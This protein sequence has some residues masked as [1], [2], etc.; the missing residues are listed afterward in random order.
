[1]LRI[2]KIFLAL[3]FLININTLQLN[4]G[5]AYDND[6]PITTDTRIKTYIYNQNEVYLLVMHYGFQ[7]FIEFAKNEI[8]ETI[9]MGDS[10][11]WKIT[12][13][14]NRLFLKPLEKNIRT[15]MTVMTN[16]RIY[17]FDVV[18]K[19]FEDGDEKDLVYTV[20]FFYPKNK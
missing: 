11:A 4:N 18:A 19:P 13:M 5:Y 16:K 10:Y 2:N 1:M 8:I 20:R 7:S 17:Q 12:P 3:I 15:N 6:I 14:G 9:S